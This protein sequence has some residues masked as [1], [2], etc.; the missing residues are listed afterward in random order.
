MGPRGS[1]GIATRLRRCRRGRGHESSAPGVAL[2][3]GHAAALPRSGSLTLAGPHP[4]PQWHSGVEL[5]LVK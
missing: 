1:G 5:T 2:H 3:P 4:H